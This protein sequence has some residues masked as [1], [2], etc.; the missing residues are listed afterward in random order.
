M[1]SPS[2]AELQQMQDELRTAL[3][4]IAA[5]AAEHQALQKNAQEA[6]AASEARSTQLIKTMTSAWPGD[7]FESVRF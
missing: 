5:L 2:M 7:K 3:Q 6:I 1:A 4:Q